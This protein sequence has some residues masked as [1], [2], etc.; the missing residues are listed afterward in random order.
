MVFQ[1]RTRE[2]HEQ[3]ESGIAAHKG[4]NGWALLGGKLDTVDLA[5]RASWLSSIREVSTPLLIRHTWTHIYAPHLCYCAL[6]YGMK[7]PMLHVFK[8]VVVFTN[9]CIHTSG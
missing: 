5:R 1:I 3:A 9:A 8:Q 2:M 7:N 6:L 4:P